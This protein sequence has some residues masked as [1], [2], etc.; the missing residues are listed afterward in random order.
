MKQEILHL[1]LDINVPNVHRF[2]TL[3]FP[4]MCM[5]NQKARSI[6]VLNQNMHLFHLMIFAWNV[7]LNIF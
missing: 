2:K 1:A 4:H 5:L 7:Y 6:G 3:L